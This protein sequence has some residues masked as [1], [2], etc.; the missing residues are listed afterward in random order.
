M[1]NGSITTTFVS[2]VARLGF[3]DAL[4]QA[5]SLIGHEVSNGSARLTIGERIGDGLAGAV[6]YSG[7][8]RTGSPLL[9]SVRVDVVVT[10]WS[11]GRL[12]IGLR[13]LSRLGSASSVRAN[14]F[15]SAAWR[16]MPSLV[17]ALG[18]ST[19]AERPAVTPSAVAA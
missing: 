14:R 8:L 2:Q 1:T 19:V 15:F 4:E 10:P 6:W 9:P 11:A 3:A 12:E 18:A 13:P 5:D 17:S 16:I 7:V